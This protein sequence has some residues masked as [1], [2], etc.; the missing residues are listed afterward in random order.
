MKGRADNGR[1]LSTTPALLRFAAKCRHDAVTGCVNWIGGQ[2]QG[3][4]HHVPYGSFWFEGRRWFAHRWAAKFIHGLEIDGQGV[5]V[6]HVC[7]NTLCVE[8]LQAV[9]ANVN[10][11]LQAIRLQVGLLRYEDVYGP[12]AGDVGGMPWFD[13]PKWLRDAASRLRPPISSS[14]PRQ[15]ILEPDF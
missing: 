2:T 3:R 13:E 10:R 4:G 14:R 12:M 11:A 1:F 9:P 6:D 5:Q 7:T 15:A 8:H